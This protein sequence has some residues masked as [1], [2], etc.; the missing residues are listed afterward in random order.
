MFSV[1]T[2]EAVVATIPK[3]VVQKCITSEGL[4]LTSSFIL[5]QLKIILRMIFDEQHKSQPISRE[6]IKLSFTQVKSNKGSTG[7]DKMTI[8]EVSSNPR[9]YL[10]PLWNRLA[11]GSYFP[12]PVRQV[13]IPKADGKL[14]SLGI[15]TVLDRVAQQVIATELEAIVD[16]SFSAN[17]YGYRPKKSAHDAILSCRQNCHK[18]SFVIDL[19]IKGFFDT[20]DHDLMLQAL[21]YHTSA[22]H[23]LLYVSRWLQAPIQLLDGRLENPQGK[24]TPQGGVIS[25][26]LA[27]IFLDIVFDKWFEREFSK[28][29]FE[30]YADDI[31][32]H[33]N[34]LRQA[35]SIFTVVTKRFADCH[36]AINEE[37]SKIVYCRSNQMYRP[38]EKIEHQS[39]D[40]LGH[41]FKPR[42]IKSKVGYKLMF[43]PGMSQKKISKLTAELSEMGFHRWVYHSLSKIAE[44]LRPKLRGWIN[45]FGKFFP[46]CLRKLFRHLHFRLVRWVRNKYRRFRRKSWYH[47]LQYLQGICK[48]F[49]NLF[50]HWKYPIYRP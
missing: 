46:S 43:L 20:I 33:C 36:L 9:K 5:L 15:P 37:K 17:S 1:G 13:L 34:T 31:V 3:R 44:I 26:L 4:H 35:K 42:M 23:I 24:G 49:P 21:R 10:Y 18:H 30:R 25:P 41:T 28:Y 47:S 19:D 8:E 16:P 39:F 7:V 14:R 27:N 38:T 12:K 22:K 48:Q 50:E 2:D 6:Q 29:T 11:S 40:F 45:Y 32:I